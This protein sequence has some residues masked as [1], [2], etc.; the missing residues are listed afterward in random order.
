MSE[1]QKFLK[2]IGRRIAELREAKG[3]TQRQLGALCDKDG[4]SINRVEQGATNPTVYY[5]SELAKGLECRICDI[6][7]P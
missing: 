2:K 3:L 1:K 6:T 5:L 7:D 4:Q